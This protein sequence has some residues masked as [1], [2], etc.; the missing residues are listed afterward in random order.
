M[1]L[2]SIES[3]RNLSP[4]P[5]PSARVGPRSTVFLDG[6]RGLAAFYVVLHHAFWLL[7]E[8][9]TAGYL[10]HPAS[11]TTLQYYVA[12]FSAVLFRFG[13]VAVLF[14]F[15]LSGFVIHLRYARRIVNE[16]ARADFGWGDFVYRRARRLYPP[17]LAA[18]A[19]TYA[20]DHLGASLAFAIYQ[21]K[22][23]YPL[24]NSSVACNY[25]WRTFFGN[26]A[27]LQKT[28][29][30]CWGSDRPLWSLKYEWWFYMIYPCLWP[31]LRRSFSAASGAIVL[32]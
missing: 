12:L 26:L 5:A 2:V 29:V 25:G 8:G 1:S 16:P 24:I 30:P 13:H 20:L 31:I 14:F 19:I 32:F 9:Y 7:Q 28:Y 23:P 15:V 3:P 4:S 6:L 17:L 22:T 21:S 10:A 18:L 27:F 11:Y